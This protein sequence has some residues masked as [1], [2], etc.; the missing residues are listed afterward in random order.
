MSPRP[1]ARRRVLAVT[2]QDVSGE[3]DVPAAATLRAWARAAAA[4]RGETGGRASESDAVRGGRAGELTIRIV[5]TAESAELNAR[6]RGKRGPTN[7]LSFDGELPDLP[8]ADLVAPLGDLVICAPV[9]VAE[10][11]EQCKTPEAHWAHMVV[12]GVLHLLGYDHEADSDAQIMEE[13]ERN[14]LFK[15]GFPDPW[16]ATGDNRL[17]DTR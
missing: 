9:V 8:G 3:S 10:A 17:Q 14:I 12:H 16:L 7:V 6:Y 15:L 4:G 5:G 11:A 13:R 2:I 1:A